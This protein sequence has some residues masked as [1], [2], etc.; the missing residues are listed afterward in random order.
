MASENSSRNE[1][2]GNGPGLLELEPDGKGRRDRLTIRTNG[3]SELRF[4]QPLSKAAIV[5]AVTGAREIEAYDVASLVHGERH[6]D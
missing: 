1:D 4:T 3:G 5:S 6:G 2:R